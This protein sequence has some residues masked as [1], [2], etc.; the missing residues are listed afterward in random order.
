MARRSEHGKE[1][2]VIR[3]EKLGKYDY[4]VYV[5]GEQDAIGKAGELCGEAWFLARASLGGGL[6]W[7]K[8]M[9]DA[10]KAWARDQQQIKRLRRLILLEMASV[11]M[12]HDEEEKEEE[13]LENGIFIE[14]RG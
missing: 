11:P 10:V 12:P 4:A 6:A 9:L 5:K 13:E 8:T 1:K 3:F 2:R 14:S 7:D